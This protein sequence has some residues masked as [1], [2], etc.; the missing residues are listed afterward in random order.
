METRAE[1]ANPPTGAFVEVDGHPVHYTVTGDGPD[2]VMIHGASGNVND[3][4]IALIPLLSDRYRVIVFDRPGFGYTP[5][6]GDDAASLAEQ[7]RLLADAA[8]ALG[9]DRPLVLGQSYGGSVALAWALERPRGTAG[10]VLVS[11]ASNPWTTGIGAYYQVLSSRFGQWLGVP[12]LT[13]WTSDRVIDTTLDYIFAPQD[14]PEGYAEAFGARLSLRRAP[15]RENALERER[16]LDEISAQV[17]RY[18][19]IRVPVEVLHGT[20]DEIVPH[21]VHSEPLARQLPDATLTLLE[22][23]GHMPHH[24][25]TGEVAAAVDRAAA[26]AGLR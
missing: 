19:A 23:I 5:R 12:V 4:D 13:A 3:F 24:V 25:A 14:V 11:A 15:L 26:R 10:L 8:A 18:P 9:A 22:G 21:D 6:L 17:V 1:A 20:A 2:L 7:A 16:L